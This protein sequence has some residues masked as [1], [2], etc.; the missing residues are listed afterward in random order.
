MKNLKTGKYQHYKG[1]Y[2][3]VI[4]LARHSETLEELVT[5]RAL[6]ESEEFGKNALWAR[7]KSMFLENVD[8]NGKSIPRFRFILPQKHLHSD[9]N[10]VK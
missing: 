6:Y 3:E 9:E 10:P 7:P 5:Y 1:K 4:G 8:V 2:Y